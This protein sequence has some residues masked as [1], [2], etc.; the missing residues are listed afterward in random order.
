MSF[1]SLL[2]ILLHGQLPRARCSR[3]LLFGV[4]LLSATG[5]SRL[6]TPL[7]CGLPR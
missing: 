3:L 5:G 2:L 1:G 7:W 6:C 4:L